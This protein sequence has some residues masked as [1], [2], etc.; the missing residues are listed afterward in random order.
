M[1]RSEF[2]VPLDLR[3]VE[4]AGR[5]AGELPGETGDVALAHAV[6]LAGL[7]VDGDLPVLDGL[8]D[9]IPHQSEPAGRL[10]HPA[11]LIDRGGSNQCQASATRTASSDA[12]GTGSSACP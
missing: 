11:Y 4:F 8:R 6:V 9:D 12:S 10:E 3:E 1:V 7:T 2:P 5:D